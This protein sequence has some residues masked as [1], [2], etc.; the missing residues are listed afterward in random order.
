MYRYR[1]EGPALRQLALAL[2]L[3]PAL[4][5]LG[6]CPRSAKVYLAS[7]NEHLPSP[8]FTIEY[9]EGASAAAVIRVTDITDRRNQQVV[10]LAQKTLISDKPRTTE[11]EY[12]VTPVGFK[13][14]EGPEPLQP[15]HRY[16]VSIG[17]DLIDIDVL[18]DGQVRVV[19]GQNGK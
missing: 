12:G 6:G 13:T 15:G 14:K 5:V 19:P 18:A 8:R 2:L 10:W 16:R 11:F 17:H 9:D 7:E 3:L 4:L 1:R